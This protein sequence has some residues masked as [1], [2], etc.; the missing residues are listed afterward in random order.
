MKTFSKKV[1]L[2]SREAMVEF[3][4]NHYRYDTANSWNRSTSYANDMKIYNLELDREIEENLLEMLEIKDS[5]FRINALLE[6]FGEAHNWYWQVGFNGRSGGYLVLYQGGSKQSENK[7]FCIA[8]GQHNFTSVNETGTKCG[9]CGKKTRVDFVKPP[10]ETFCYPGR[11]TDQ[12]EDFE[13][14]DMGTLK[15]RVRLVQEFDK[16]CDDVV[17]AAVYMAERFEIEEEEILATQ[18]R[19]VLRNKD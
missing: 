14:W 11:G 19:R 1:D 13:G 12:D 9:R 15:C 2:R 10:V 7:S 4:V 5:Y 18:T 6:E 17:T 3:L 16:L 8:C